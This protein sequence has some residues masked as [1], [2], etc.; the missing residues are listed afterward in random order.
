L[1]E[2]H[3]KN[4]QSDQMKE[5][6][7]PPKS[8]SKDQNNQMEVN[9][10]VEPILF[11]K[12]SHSHMHILKGYYESI[13]DDD[14]L[15]KIFRRRKQVQFVNGFFIF[16]SLKSNV[17]GLLRQTYPER[18][19]DRIS[20]CKYLARAIEI[21][22]VIE[23]GVGGYKTLI[24][25]LNKDK[26]SNKCHISIQGMPNHVKNNPAGGI[27]HANEYKTSGITNQSCHDLP[28]VTND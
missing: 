11:P 24:L 25:P 26:D 28:I 9:Q 17:G 15:I 1:F 20:V 19:L 7:V 3:G 4:V 23:A 27:T 12:D 22:S 10:Y 8:V 18:I 21:G 2:A 5:A 13:N 14:L 6:E 16:S